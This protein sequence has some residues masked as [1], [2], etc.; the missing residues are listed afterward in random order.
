M[1]SLDWANHFVRTPSRHAV[2][3]SRNNYVL[4]ESADPRLDARIRNPGVPQVYLRYL[5]P[6]EGSAADPTAGK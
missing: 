3:S 1:E 6:K 5:F 4:F 2:T